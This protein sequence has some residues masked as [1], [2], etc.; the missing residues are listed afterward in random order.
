MDLEKLKK[1]H[2]ELYKKVQEEALSAPQNEIE[3]LKKKNEELSAKVTDLEKEKTDLA[4]EKKKNDDRIASLEKA[5]A[6]RQEKDMR[7]KAEAI[8]DK[9]LSESKIPKRLH[10]RVKKAV[11]F[12]EHVK[13]SVFDDVEFAKQFDAEIKSWADDLEAEFADSATILGFSTG[14]EADD[15]NKETEDLSDTLVGFVSEATD[16]LEK[17]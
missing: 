8:K 11:D 2:P 4:D 6:L 16:I 13:E 17:K 15:K 1:E 12:N 5:E 7:N 10:E 14:G 9:K 3:D